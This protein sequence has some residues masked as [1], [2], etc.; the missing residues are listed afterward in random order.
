MSQ[1][2]TLLLH[3]RHSLSIVVL[4][5]ALQIIFI[6]ALPPTCNSPS[7][8]PLVLG[9]AQTDTIFTSVAYD[10]ADSGNIF[11]GG[12][13]QQLN[14]DFTPVLKY[15]PI[16]IK[17]SSSSG[18][19][20]WKKVISQEDAIVAGIAVDSGNIAV[21]C[22][23]QP[24]STTVFVFYI[25]ALSGTITTGLIVDD[26]TLSI[27]PPII[28][29][30]DHFV[31]QY[32][33]SSLYL[34]QPQSLYHI[35]DTASSPTI[36]RYPISVGQYL[37]GF[38]IRPAGGFFIIQYDG[39]KIFVSY[40]TGLPNAGPA[41][42]TT[43]QI[44]CAG[45]N[46]V[47]YDNTQQSSKDVIMMAGGGKWIN[48]VIDV[49]PLS[50]QRLQP[51][52][53]SI[54]LT[55]SIATLETQAIYA[56]GLD[57]SFALFYDSNTQ[58]IYTGEIMQNTPK[59]YL[60][61]SFSKVILST[62]RQGAIILSNKEFFFVGY[63]N[64][65]QKNPSPTISFPKRQGLM[66]FKGDIG[67]C[68]F[69]PN[70]AGDQSASVVNSFIEAS[71]APT[72]SFTVSPVSLTTISAITS[73]LVIAGSTD[74]S[75]VCT[76][77]E[78]ASIT[79]TRTQITPIAIAYNIGDFPLNIDLLPLFT[80]TGS[81]PTQ[82]SAVDLALTYSISCSPNPC[83]PYISLLGT[84]L[85]INTLGMTSNVDFTDEVVV[86][87][88]TKALSQTTITYN[89][90]G[91][92]NKKPY[93][94]QSFPTTEFEVTAGVSTV[95]TRFAVADDNLSDVIQATLEL[96][97]GEPIPDYIQILKTANRLF[98]INVDGT[99]LYEGSDNYV[100]IMGSDGIASVSLGVIH[101][102]I[103]PLKSSFLISN[104]GPPVFIESLQTIY[105]YPGV[106]SN[107]TLPGIID[108]DDDNFT[109]SLQLG[110]LTSFA[111]FAVNT[112]SFN[113]LPNQNYKDTYKATIKLTDLN[114][115]PQSS[116]YTLL[117]RLMGLSSTNQTLTPSHANATNI[118]FTLR[119]P[120]R[121]GSVRLYINSKQS[122]YLSNQIARQLNESDF[123]LS[124][125]GQSTVNFTFEE[126]KDNIQF[127]YVTVYMRFEGII[128]LYDDPLD[129]VE[130]RA[131]NDII[132]GIEGKQYMIVKKSGASVE[133]PNQY[134][135]EGVRLIQR[136][137]EVANAMQIAMI[138]G[139]IL[140]N[141][142]L[143]MA[144]NLI[145]S[146]LNDLSFMINMAMIS[147]SIP[148]VAQPIMNIVLQFI[149]LDILQTDKWL[150]PI[151][152]KDRDEQ[153]NL[154]Q[155]EPLSEYFEQSGFQS[156]LMLKNLGSTLI[157]S[158]LLLF[159]YIAYLLSTG[160]G[161]I[162][163][164]LTKLAN[165]LEGRL[166]WGSG[167]R[168]VIQQFQPLMIT[169]IIN[170]YSI[171][172]DSM[173]AFAST[174]SA[175]GTIIVMGVSVW[176]MKVSLEGDCSKN[177]KPLIEGINTETII[178]RYWMPITLLKWAILSL[179]LVTLRNYPVLQLSLVSF[180]SFTSQI[181]LITGKPFSTPLENSMSL[182]NELMASLYLYGL[183]TLTDSMG[184]NLVKEECGLAMLLLVLFTISVNL[185]KV[186]IQM[187][188]LI[189]CKKKTHANANNTR[190]GNTREGRVVKIKPQSEVTANTSAE[191]LWYHNGGRK[192]VV[193]VT[194]S[195]A[196]DLRQR[197]YDF[198]Y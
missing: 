119:K 56:K 59:I 34:Q 165:I 32:S 133:V 110:E 10:K 72:I 99:G 144:M 189:K 179:T 80:V 68:S 167:I 77:S 197:E 8:N 141:I 186:L 51:Y 74:L 163:L 52:S 55:T 87:A 89:L 27:L 118:T 2:L 168:F 62:I 69:Q 5:L 70:T 160:L 122:L 153:G 138:P 188:L 103:K 149:Y 35:D 142:F 196:I 116:K 21:I 178:G 28:Q 84:S 64:V 46:G 48:L 111:T 135:V 109:I 14:T 19:Q 169:S 85:M 105:I 173:V 93:L 106:P 172:F 65:I 92:A 44:S 78:V 17:I 57:Q 22:N 125:N 38:I 25:S 176:R 127:G 120:T 157:F 39:I 134:S 11:V 45:V 198:R 175:F 15:F 88:E 128:S 148:G 43:F 81:C 54:E 177:C 162:Y 183:F 114:L 37:H 185:L 130:I 152:A 7:N 131:E 49:S 112:F 107:F 90:H 123:S 101:I 4:L 161:V 170:V 98:E 181:L 140:I 151:F 143:Q 16:I 1:F 124:L 113:P 33:T 63:N 86:T 139:S 132:M 96:Q 41:F 147:I 184:R 187:S 60:Y 117:I 30:R 154:L 158:A 129:W 47:A 94:A 58:L 95:I 145:W 82:L 97:G 31:Y 20:I 104:Y 71:T 150:T 174:A 159:L 115:K 164:P 100:E 76:K 9:G 136:M 192:G 79:A 180:L 12:A 121:D 18:V 26:A 13:T 193:Q 6:Q 146:M 50:T 108:P 182:F 67:T 53:Q 91:I 137:Q 171:K 29:R 36:S 190:N 40:Y 191:D 23:S 42:Q 102:T 61:T 195:K 155:D 126:D 66:Y 83:S 73:D 3:Q 166:F 24:I 156:M 194:A 75:T